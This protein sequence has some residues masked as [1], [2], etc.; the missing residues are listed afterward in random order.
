MN[1]RVLAGGIMLSVGVFS[2]MLNEWL[3]HLFVVYF[4]MAKG[5]MLEGGGSFTPLPEHS[6]LEL[7]TISLGTQILIWLLVVGCGVFLLTAVIERFF[8]CK[9]EK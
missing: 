7:V 4:Y 3:R 5:S 6:S 2:Q 1:N 8:L 9:K